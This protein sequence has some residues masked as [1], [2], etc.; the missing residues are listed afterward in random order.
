MFRRLS[1]LGVCVGNTKTMDTI[2]SFCHDFDYEVKKW[3]NA[4]SVMQSEDTSIVSQLEEEIDDDWSTDDFSSDDDDIQLSG[5][6]II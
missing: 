5:K 2:K 6:F 4:V 1:Q 3:Q